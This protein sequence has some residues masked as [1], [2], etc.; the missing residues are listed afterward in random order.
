MVKEKQP[1]LNQLMAFTEELG[2][3]NRTFAVDKEIVCLF[4][5]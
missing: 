5:C 4:Y 3:Q 1:K 2:K